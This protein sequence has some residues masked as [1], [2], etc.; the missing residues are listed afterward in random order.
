MNVDPPKDPAVG[1]D[2]K[3][4]QVIALD[5]GNFSVVLAEFVDYFFPWVW[6]RKSKKEKEEKKSTNGEDYLREIFFI[7]S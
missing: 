5:P 4:L 1:C 2:H 7:M 6:N 3:I